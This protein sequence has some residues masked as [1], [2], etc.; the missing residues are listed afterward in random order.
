M[1]YTR[2]CRGC[3]ALIRFLATRQG[4]WIPVDLDVLTLWVT[5]R[6]ARGETPRRLSLVT[7]L[8]ETVHGYE[9]DQYA[10][11]AFTIRGYVPHFATCARADDFRR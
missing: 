1:N 8:G 4:K 6:P 11:E 2:T 10:P 9:S 3:G 7:E 5:G